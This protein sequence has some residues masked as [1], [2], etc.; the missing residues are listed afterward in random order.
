[1]KF[2]ENKKGLSVRLHLNPPRIAVLRRTL[3][4]SLL[5]TQIILFISESDRLE[6]VNVVTNEELGA[7]AA[8][9]AAPRV[10]MQELMDYVTACHP[11]ARLRDSENILVSKNTAPKRAQVQNC[12]GRCTG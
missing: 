3:D 2:A 7:L 11:D 9:L 5:S 12:R 10:G 6:G 8:L 4:I 1:M